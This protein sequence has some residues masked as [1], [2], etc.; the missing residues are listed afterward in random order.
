MYLLF[1]NYCV[2]L[3]IIMKT[4]CLLRLCEYNVLQYKGLTGVTVTKLKSLVAL[5][6]QGIFFMAMEQP[7][8]QLFFVCHLTGLLDE[9]ELRGSY[10]SLNVGT[11]L[12]NFIL[13][14]TLSCKL[15]IG[16]Q[17]S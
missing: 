8:R 9:H 16:R 15:S 7:M 10:V 12:F 13:N 14:T 11:S 5:S 6:L 1:I 4:L 3:H 2:S 17:I